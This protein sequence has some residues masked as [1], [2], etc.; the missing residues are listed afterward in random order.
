LHEIRKLSRI[1]IRAS[2]G[3]AFFIVDVRLLQIDPAQHA[4]IASRAP[5]GI[6]LVLLSAR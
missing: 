4:T 6:D 3:G 1:E 2:A 5:V